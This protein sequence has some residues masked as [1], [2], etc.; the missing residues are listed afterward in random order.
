MGRANPW[1]LNHLATQKLFDDGSFVAYLG[2][3]QYFA[4][5]EY[6]KFLMYAVRHRCL[7]LS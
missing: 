4:R 1:Y 6:A 7:D 3:L 5:P 2:Y